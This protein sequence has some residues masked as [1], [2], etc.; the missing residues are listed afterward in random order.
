MCNFAVHHIKTRIIDQPDPKLH[1]GS[2]IL[3]LRCLAAWQNVPL[4]IK[5]GSNLA[6][7]HPPGAGASRADLR[8]S[9]FFLRSG[10]RRLARM[11][12]PARSGLGCWHARRAESTRTCSALAARTL[13]GEQ[14]AINDIALRDAA[15][16]AKISG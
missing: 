6:G 11:S 4:L 2:T 9:L 16:H 1:S 10:S 14:Q 15:Q 12:A 7:S 13:R 3:H 5:G 8:L